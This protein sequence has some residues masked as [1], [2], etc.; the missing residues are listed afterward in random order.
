VQG[1]GQYRPRRVSSRLAP[2]EGLG[3]VTRAWRHAARWCPHGPPPCHNNNDTH[4]DHDHQVQGGRQCGGIGRDRQRPTAPKVFTLP[5]RRV[6]LPY[7]QRPQGLGRTATFFTFAASL[8]VRC[9]RQ[10]RAK[11]TSRPTCAAPPVVCF[12]LQSS[13][14]RGVLLLYVGDGAKTSM[15]PPPPLPPR[16]GQANDSPR[17][18]TNDAA[19]IDAVDVANTIMGAPTLPAVRA[20]GGI[21]PRPIHTALSADDAASW[22]FEPEN[23]SGTAESSAATSPAPAT[24]VVDVKG[25]A[26]NAA[27]A[28]PQAAATRSPRVRRT[29]LSSPVLTALRRSSTKA[30]ALYA[31]QNNALVR[32]PLPVRDRYQ[33]AVDTPI[34]QPAPLSGAVVRRS[35]SSVPDASFA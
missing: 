9:S 7:Y 29:A 27:D 23:S 32:L 24:M 26:L 13:R 34:L 1:G 25:Q 10:P 2:A 5:Q 19:D 12:C 30:E 4:G 35:M 3:Q 18:A 16:R 20:P 22:F 8:P 21:V 17:A 33:L 11:A 28:P 31:W 15:R 14:L 6:A